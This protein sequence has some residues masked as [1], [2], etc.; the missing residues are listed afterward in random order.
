MYL[1]SMTWLMIYEL[2]IDDR[3]MHSWDTEPI[4]T[5]INQIYIRWFCENELICGMGWVMLGYTITPLI[6]HSLNIIDF[7]SIN[8]FQ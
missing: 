1:V 3:K 2:R 7:Q 8:R 6:N 5:T 4:R